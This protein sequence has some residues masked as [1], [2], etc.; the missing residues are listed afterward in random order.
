MSDSILKVGSNST[1]YFKD[2]L[3]GIPEHLEDN[4]VNLVFTSPPYYNYI[5]YGD[6]GI[7]NEDNYTEYIDNL[8]SVFKA[9]L[10]KFAEGG[11]LVINITNLTSK[12]DKVKGNYVHPIVPDL[13]TELNKI[14]YIFFDECIWIKA[15]SYSGSGGR[16]LFG[17]YPYPP[18]PKLMNAM[19]ENIL[20]FRVPGKRP[21]VSDEIKEQSKISLNDWRTYTNGLWRIKPDRNKQHPASFPIELAN[22]IIRLYSFV[23]DVVL[24][25]FVGTGT[26]VIASELLNRVGVGFEVNSKF[27]SVAQVKA[28]RNIDEILI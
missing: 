7:G 4:S 11:R 23:G 12:N 18:T 8:V 19:Y 1:I 14:G 10:P 13:I 21:K 16:P 22:R 20:V 25:P 2:S 17:S 15:D 24:D 5:Y 26:S 3:V 9:C 6:S 27:Y 28:S